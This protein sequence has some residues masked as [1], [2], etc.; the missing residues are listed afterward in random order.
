MRSHVLVR[1][2]ARL[3]AEDT[4]GEGVPAVFQHGLGG[5]ALQVAEAF[6]DDPRFR[7]LTLECRGHGRSQAGPF[8]SL[9]IATFADDVAATIEAE[10]LRPVVVGGISMGAAV[11]LRLAVRRPDLVRA[12]VL[13]RPAWVV[14][15]APRNMAATLEVG[16]L[17]Q[18]L[19]AAEARVAFEA[20]ETARRLSIEAPDNLSTLLGFFERPAQEVTAALLTAIS[21]DGPGISAGDVRA[22]SIPTLIM[23]TGRDAIHPLTHAEDL[24]GMITGAHLLTITSK[25]DDRGAYA[26]DMRAALS[27]FLA[28]LT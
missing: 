1:D 4:G 28:K 9:S 17:L 24:A 3:Y 11:S 26:A 22:I 21:L 2:G 13:A 14:E 16:R 12:L 10:G 25:A 19:P 6:P 27:D 8:S 18:R 7:R 23:A 5:D 15:A 20:S